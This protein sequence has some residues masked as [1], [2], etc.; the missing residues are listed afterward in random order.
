MLDTPS[1]LLVLLHLNLAI[2]LC[3]T[4]LNPGEESPQTRD[5]QTTTN[6]VNYRMVWK[7]YVFC[8]V[9]SHL[10]LAS[11]NLQKLKFFLALFLLSVLSMMSNHAYRCIQDQMINYCKRLSFTCRLFYTSSAINASTVSFS[12]WSSAARVHGENDSLHPTR[13]SPSSSL[14][15]FMTMRYAAMLRSYV[16]TSN[17]SISHVKTVIVPAHPQC[18]TSLYQST[19]LR[20]FRKHLLG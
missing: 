4:T 13:P 9:W 16:H 14:M 10:Q 19:L 11:W 20:A 2:S 1:D 3:N 6:E 5:N 15:V 17:K 18:H 12:S 8:V 7:S